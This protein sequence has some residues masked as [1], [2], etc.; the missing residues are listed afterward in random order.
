[1]SRPTTNQ[2]PAAPPVGT[3]AIAA[4]PVD[5]PSAVLDRGRFLAALGAL[6]EGGPGAGDP[7]AF[8]MIAING[9]GITN[10][11]FGFE[12]GDEVVA[13]VIQTLR[14]K[15]RASDVIGHLTSNRFG[16][17]LTGCRGQ[18]DMRVAAE[19]LRRAVGEAPVQTAGCR[20]SATI[21]IGGVLLPQQAASAQEAVSR[22]LQALSRA[23]RR[24]GQGFCGYQPDHGNEGGRFRNTD[25]VKDVVSALEAG[26]MRLALQ[27][28]IS[29]TTWQPA[30]HECLLRM[31]LADGRTIAAGEFI[32]VAEQ[33]GLSRLIDR[34]A[35]ELAVEL[36][37]QQPELHASLNVS[38]LTCSDSDWLAALRR[39][40][41]R[42]RLAE[43][44]TIE[45]TETAAIQDFDQSVAFVDTLKELGCRVAVDDFGAGYTSFKNLKHLAV[46]MV[47][48]DGAFVRNLAQ[49]KSD[50]VFIRV[51]ADLARNLG[52]ESVA[53]WVGDDATARLLADAGID[54]LQGFH[55]GEPVL[56]GRLGAG[57]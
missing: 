44:L 18:A 4:H 3:G 19:R 10:E 23:K 15:L 51:M 12:A 56:A 45:I 49:D 1:V 28:I 20:L 11:T 50:Q 25:L 2:S 48:I 55:F 43:R 40:T 27:P 39:L 9:L 52:M 36:L 8:L 54:Y 42:G 29:T 6:L 17:I 7:S 24:P 32:G 30:L 38:G 33:L 37:E 34:R 35:L 13:A 41:G 47:K 16:V 53:E 26:R 5:D 46:D 57:A 14:S 22:A 31:E 21:S